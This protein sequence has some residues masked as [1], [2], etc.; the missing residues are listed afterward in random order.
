[1]GAADEIARLD[2]VEKSKI[3]A[4]LNAP[5][6]PEVDSSDN[7]KILGVSSGEWNVVDA[8]TELPAVTSTDNGKLLGVSNAAWGVVN[9]PSGLPAVT[10]DD[11]G[12]VLTVVEG[13]WAKA[14]PSSGGAET[15]DVVFDVTWNDETQSGVLTCNKTPYEL[16][17][18]I[19]AGKTVEAKLLYYSYEK[20]CLPVQ[21]GITPEVYYRFNFVAIEPTYEQ[22]S[23]VRIWYNYT[24]S[25]WDFLEDYFALTP[26]TPGS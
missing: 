13:A 23:Y 20:W 12:D 11:N 21:V 2:F 14:T 18:D 22:L 16:D 8:P 1:M 3:E 17:A 6:L 15:V 19:M 26:Y 9:A 25:K 24:Q 7:G 10:S 5:V 4:L